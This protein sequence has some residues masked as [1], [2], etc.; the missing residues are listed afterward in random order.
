MPAALVVTR[1]GEGAEAALHL[2]PDDVGLDQVEPSP[3]GLVAHRQQG[4]D[5]D[6]TGVGD[7]WEEV[8]VVVEDV[9]RGPV[10]EGGEGRRREVLRPDAAASTAAPW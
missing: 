7:R 6:R 8:V 5:E 3:A 9:R 4:G 2:Q 10:D 1:V